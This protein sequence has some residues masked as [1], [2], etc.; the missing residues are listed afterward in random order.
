MLRE[1][2]VRSASRLLLTGMML[3]A[4]GG[5]G[6]GN[7]GGVNTI[8]LP[9]P[10]N[11]L[12]SLNTSDATFNEEHHAGSQSCATCHNYDQMLIDADEPGQTRNVSIGTAWETSVMAN[13]TR[14][15]YWHAVVAS[16]LDNF[17]HLEDKINDE[18]TVCHAPTAHD[19]AEKTGLDLRLFDKGSVAEGDFQQGIY[20]MDDSSSLFNHAMDGVSC[21]LCHQ[22]E[23]SNFGTEESM[24][25]GYV[26]TGSPTGDLA[27]R[28]AYGQYTDPGVGYMRQQSQFL[29]QYGPHISTS[30]SCATCHNLTIEPVDPRGA[31]LEEPVHFAE[32]AVYTEWLLSDFSV[33]GPKEASCQTCHMPKVDQDVFIAEGADMMRPDF[34]EHTFLGP[35]TVLQ[36][37]LGNFADE[38]GIDPDLDFESAIV[39]NREF[40]KS[41]ASISLSQGSVQV[42]DDQETHT[43]SFDVTVENQTGHK[44]PSGYHSRRVYLHVQVLDQNSELV[45]ESGR[46]NPDGSIVGVSED[47]DPS[48][49]E[50]HHD[51]ITAGDQ[52][53]VYQAIMGNS[54]GARTHSLLAGT[55]YLK[56]NRLT[57]SGFDKV[58]ATN[59]PTFADSFGVFGAAYEDDDFDSGGDIVSYQVAVPGPGVYT[60]LAELRYQPLNFGHLQ[61]LWTQGDR[62]DQVDMFR[63][64]YNATELRDEFIDTATQIMQ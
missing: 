14:D 5:C 48:T 53:Q 37:M 35:N 20:S 28:P 15:P 29:P 27:D 13:S 16:E 56:D 34:A 51:V 38:L 32:Q 26:I 44:L 30:E 2:T 63:T 54:E 24:T 59:D 3:V 9:Q 57:P 25:G 1:N 40:L 50:P 31:E 39:R 43:L 11:T 45:F 55:F 62:V 42:E 52:V 49:W 7:N 17:P 36:D 23:G 8:E 61:Q 60:V 47:L 10:R 19:L 4:L 46:I 18:C 12:P 58:A 21:T 33:G 22:M 41:A 64:I 6:G